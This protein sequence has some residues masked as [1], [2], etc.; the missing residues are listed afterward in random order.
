MF[1]FSS[2]RAVVN[3]EGTSVLF[4]GSATHA[5]SNGLAA[6]TTGRE[7]LFQATSEE[8]IEAYSHVPRYIA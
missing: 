3:L 4:N 2:V 7:M 6:G 5:D 8:M 1:T